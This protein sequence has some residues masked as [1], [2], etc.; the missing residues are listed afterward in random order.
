MGP[1]H[2][3]TPTLLPEAN[4]PRMLY[5]LRP[6]QANS[7]GRML[8]GR[9]YTQTMSR[10]HA[11]LAQRLRIQQTCTTLAILSQMG[12][13]GVVLTQTAALKPASPEAVI[14]ASIIVGTP[15]LFSAA[16]RSVLNQ[17]R[18]DSH[19]VKIETGMNQRYFPFSHDACSNLLT[20]CIKHKPGVPCT[21]DGCERIFSRVDNMKDHVRRIHRKTS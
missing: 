1:R 17:G 4:P 6:I 2:R 19:H 10:Y 11:T 12:S 16:T 13:A 3:S 20:S 14:Y 7:I 15:K 18:G 5:L 9:P 8:R 21:H